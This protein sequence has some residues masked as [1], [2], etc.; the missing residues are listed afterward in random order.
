MEMLEGI[1]P[2][3]APGFDGKIA[4][5]KGA[6]DQH[7]QEEESELFP[8]VREL[9]TSEALESLAQLM[10]AEAMRMMQCGAPRR[11]VP[12]KAEVPRLQLSVRCA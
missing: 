2:P 9:M 3:S 5:L 10:E 7:V 12:L 4:K 1:G 6:I 11:T 8:I